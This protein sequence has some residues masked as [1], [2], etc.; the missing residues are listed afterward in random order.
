MDTM[1]SWGYSFSELQEMDRRGELL[2]RYKI[3]EARRAA[4]AEL[5]RRST[6]RK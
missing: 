4:A 3:A 1:V 2:R 6:R 5:K